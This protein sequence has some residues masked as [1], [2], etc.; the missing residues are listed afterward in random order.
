MVYIGSKRRVAKFI[1][2]YITKYLTEDRWYVEP[3]CGGCNML[4]T[5]VHGKRIAADNSLPLI[6]VFKRLQSGE[7]LPDY[8]SKEEYYR[9]KADKES[10]E[11]W[12][13]G[14]LAFLCSFRGFAWSGYISSGYGKDGKWAD[15]QRQLINNFLKQREKIQGV[16]FVCSSYEKLEIPEGSVVY[17]DPPYSNKTGYAKN[18]KSD[19]DTEKFFEWCRRKTAEGCDVLI[20]EYTAPADFTELWN[21]EINM[22]VGSKAHR[23]VEKLFVHE[24]IADRYV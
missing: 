15:V 24:S 3:F 21:G 17:C 4:E 2:P 9:V 8:I 14:F 13:V 19:F 22:N 16:K 5:V 11:P 12:Y 20:S 10:Y 6:E 23:V 1:L 18:G 7:S